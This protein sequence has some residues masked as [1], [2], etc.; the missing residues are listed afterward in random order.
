MVHRQI[1]RRVRNLDHAE[2]SDRL[3]QTD[4]LLLTLSRI[5]PLN[6]LFAACNFCIGE[7]LTECFFKV[8]QTN[9]YKINNT[10]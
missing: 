8:L 3:N 6:Y 9:L 10:R 1:G 2:I 4:R 5:D 7:V